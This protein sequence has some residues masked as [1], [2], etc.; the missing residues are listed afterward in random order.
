[1]EPTI[2]NGQTVLVSSIPYFFSKPKIGD[3]VAFKKDNK[4][5]IKRIG[6]IDGKKYFV[7]GDNKED[8][9]DSRKFGWLTKKDILGKVIL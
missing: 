5:L 1:M 3:V 7:S 9:M 2:Q 6:K 8:S 4:V